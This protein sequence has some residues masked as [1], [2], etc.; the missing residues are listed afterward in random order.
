MLRHLMNCTVLL[1]LA[2]GIGSP[3]CGAEVQ[4]VPAAVVVSPGASF[5][6]RLAAQEIRRYVYLRTASL[7]PIVED[8]ARAEGGLI[9]VGSKDRPVVKGFLDDAALKAGVEGL[10]AEQY[11]LRSIRHR[12]QSVVLVVG[13][14]ATGTLYAAYRLAEHLGVRFYLDGDVLPDGRIPL[15]L[16]ALDEVGKPLFDRR[17]I[18]PFHDFPEGPD[19]WNADGYKAILAQLPKLRMNFFGLHTYPEGG[20]GPEPL[21]WIGVAGNVGPEGKVKSSYPSRHFTA[22]NGTW[23]YQ[24]MKTGDYRFGAAALFERDDYGADY[25]AGMTPWPPTAEA[26]NELFDRM[27]GL[28]RE[29]FTFARRLGIKTCLGTET[30]LVIPTPV[31]KRLQAAG[32]DPRDPTVVQ[33]VYEGIFR[34]ISRTHPLDYYWFWTPEGW[35]WGA[36]SQQQIDATQAD[37]RAAIAAAEKTRA[38][39]T[40]ATCGWVL[41]P[42]QQPA[43]FDQTLPKS[44]PMS[45]INRQVGHTPVEPGFAEVKGRPKWAIPWMEDDPTLNS[46]QLWAGRMRKDAADALAY[47]CTGLMGI[48]WRTRILG[49]NV[50]ALAQAAWDQHGWI[51]ARNAK[52]QHVEARG[53]EGP[54][55]GQMAA[56]PNNTIAGTQQAPVYQ[57]VR[58]NVR[59]YRLDLPD[60]KYKV[61][62]QFCEPHYRQPN[63]RVFSVRLQGKLVLDRLDI[64]A[65]VGGNRALD[66]TFPDVVVSGGRLNIEFLPQVE[67]PS[68]AGI[69]VQGPVVRKIN[70]GGPAWRDYQADWPASQAPNDDDRYLPT[71]DFYADWARAQFGPQVA[72]R[73]GVIF[74]R[75]DCHLPHP[76]DWIDGPG[77][78]R[79]NEQPWA[80]VRKAYGF[81]DELEA[82]ESKVQGEGN[83]ERF[84]YWLNT[85]RYMRSSAETCCLWARLNAAVAKVK[86]QRDADARKRLARELALPLRKELVAQVE[87]TQQYLLATLTTTGELGSVTNWQ[88]HVLP[89]MLIR[90]GEELA[91]LLGEPLPADAMPGSVYH[92]QPRLMVPFVRTSLVAGEPLRLTAIVLG[93]VPADAAVY[94]RPLGSRPFAKAPLAHVARGVYRVTL[95]AEAAQADL[96]YY[97]QV[98][99]SDGRELRFPAAAPSLCQTVVVVR[100]E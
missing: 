71:S 8:P 13:G 57:T 74:A 69:V 77:G 66:Y 51:P 67:F 52:I 27:G 42:P 86:A 44:M 32:K 64:F 23:G 39:F 16:P 41:G 93:I 83:R 43:L 80:E 26:A 21:T 2:A 53:P 99:G 98:S 92:G 76:S 94:W 84:Q 95:P 97:I 20:V 63:R 68:I 90:P 65:K 59:A 55:G 100:G 88:Q 17:G 89:S 29:S 62:L 3:A 5:A 45:C 10:A 60:G 38:P 49:P 14:D 46:P 35:T 79:P 15:S 33:A 75:I 22:A 61:T 30:P 7:V 70:C 58:Y 25:M 85:M 37:F 6:E 40:L 18:Q 34:R 28:L 1:L 50:S 91:K 9:V 56:F 47:G 19:W 36:V 31:Q 87:K 54:V 72:Q 73:A 11:L 96:E 24:A 82:L 81:V 12:G 4:V 48:H 78:F